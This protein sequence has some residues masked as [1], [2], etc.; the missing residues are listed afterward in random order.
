ML[1]TRV[2]SMAQR[3]DVSGIPRKY[4]ASANQATSVSPL[5]MVVQKTGTNIFR[6][7]VELEE[8]RCMVSQLA[9]YY[10]S[11]CNQ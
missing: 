8:S 1:I 9:Q 11:F 2:K 6:K 4:F 3:K 5:R 7:R 10:S